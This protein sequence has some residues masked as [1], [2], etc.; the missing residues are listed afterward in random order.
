MADNRDSIFGPK[1]FIH[2]F[3]QIRFFIIV[4]T[5]EKNSV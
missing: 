4:D 5:N 3:R 1:N 2:Y